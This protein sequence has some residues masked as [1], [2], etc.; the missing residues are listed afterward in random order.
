MRLKLLEP[1]LAGAAPPPSAPASSSAS[2]KKTRAPRV[3]TGKSRKGKKKKGVRR[4][5]NPYG[6]GTTG[7]DNYTIIKPF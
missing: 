5:E 6:A 4:E 7:L 3:K 1:E 2:G